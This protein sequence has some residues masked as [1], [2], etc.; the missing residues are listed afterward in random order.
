MLSSVVQIIEKMT[1]RWEDTVSSG[2]G[3]KGSL[4]LWGCALRLR[5]VRQVERKQR[6]ELADTCVLLLGPGGRREAGSQEGRRPRSA[7]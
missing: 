3:V 7:Q 2:E 4:G 1:G 5:R 6:D